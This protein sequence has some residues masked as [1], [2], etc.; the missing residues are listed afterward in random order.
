[1][2]ESPQGCELR[3]T[4]QQELCVAFAGAGAGRVGLRSFKAASRAASMSSA[5]SGVGADDSSG[6]CLGRDERFF[7]LFLRGF[8]CFGFFFCARFGSSGG[9]GGACGA[10]SAMTLA[11]AGDELGVSCVAGRFEPGHTML[12]QAIGSTN[13][14]RRPTSPEMAL[15]FARVVLRLEFVMARVIGFH[16]FRPIWP[17][18]SARLHGEVSRLVGFHGALV[19][20]PGVVIL[21]RA[22]DSSL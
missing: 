6:S 15:F 19:V 18:A 9:G 14:A 8:L 2:Q 21:D 12:K 20:R 7:R 16:C 10:G 5:G 22:F 1:M 11:A 17:S 3:Q 13:R 4:L